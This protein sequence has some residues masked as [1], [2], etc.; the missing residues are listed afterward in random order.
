[1]FDLFNRKKINE[2]KSRI[3]Y[4]EK[5]IEGSSKSNAFLDN[6]VSQTLYMHIFKGKEENISIKKRI[7]LLEKYLGIE[8]HETEKI[9]KFRKKKK[10]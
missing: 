4:L 2:L 6:I 9:V 10:L 3:E 1:M 5:E 7:G 8:L